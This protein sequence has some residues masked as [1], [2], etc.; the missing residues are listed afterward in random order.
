MEY[1]TASKTQILGKDDNVSILIYL[2]TLF[3]C[4]S[5]SPVIG[6]E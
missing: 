4:K 6:G 5:R 3:R 2:Y 1:D